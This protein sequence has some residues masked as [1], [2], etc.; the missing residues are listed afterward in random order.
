MPLNFRL[1]KKSLLYFTFLSIFHLGLAQGSFF[2]ILEYGAIN[3]GKTINTKAIQKAID[4]CAGKGGGTVYFPAGNYVSGT[5]FLKSF[6]SLHLESGAV[7]EGSKNIEDYTVTISKIRAYTDNYANKSLIFGEDLEYISI[8]GHGIIDGNG[9]SFQPSAELQKSDRFAWY[10]ARPMMIRI[11]NCKKVRVTEVTLR[12]SA[13]W[14]ELY[15]ACEDV[16]ID[17]ITVNNYANANCDGI[18][19]DGCNR[20]SISNCKISS[21]D[22]A[23]CLKS[24]FDKPSRNVTITNCIISSDCSAFKLGTEST[25]G[26]ENIVLNNC[27]IYDTKKS[28]I[29]LELVDGGTLDRVS[30]S[31]VTMNNVGAAIFIRLGNRAR[32]HLENNPMA[33]LNR[34]EADKNLQKPGMGRLSDISISHVQATNVGI[35]GCSITGIP[36]FPARD[37]SINDVRIAFKGGGSSDLATKHIEEFPDKYP[38]HEMF[39][40]LPA[41]GFFCRHVKRLTLDNIDLSF[42]EP[43]YRPALFLSDVTDSRVSDMNASVE[44]RTESLI[45]IDSSKNII[46]RDCNVFKK[47]GL[48]ASIKNGSSGIIF[49]NNN[50]FNAYKMYKLDSS[51][52]KSDITIR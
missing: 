28:G 14:L 31:N 25:G 30:I 24:T 29:A 13:M 10:K 16:L 26:F 17:G 32:S 2:N 6:V 51:I 34:E 37:I 52:V 22:D 7:L 23:I 35:T 27:T 44:E 19:I 40:T 18:D 46:I 12:N 39:G 1:M 47:S 45:V 42:E 8:T 41:Y 36:M 3:D 15:Q 50:I 20:V 21:L 11:I 49:E 9:V 33:Y 43:D 4:A 5:I 38:D 48:L